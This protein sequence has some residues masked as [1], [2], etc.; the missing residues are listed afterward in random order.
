MR[1]VDTDLNIG[2]GDGGIRGTRG[3]GGG[4]ARRVGGGGGGAR[5][6]H[7]RRAARGE[8]GAAAPPRPRSSGA[9]ASSACIPPR[10]LEGRLSRDCLRPRSPACSQRSRSYL[11][12][13]RNLE[14]GPVSL[15]LEHPAEDCGKAKEE[16]VKETCPSSVAGSP[17]RHS[18]RQSPT[19]RLRGK[20][21]REILSF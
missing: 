3:G 11:A 6:H 9:A 1:C 13:E 14:K 16:G 8:E 7:Q 18:R 20:L 17:L 5:R 19:V 15:R 10:A 21:A 12:P 2:S 4:G